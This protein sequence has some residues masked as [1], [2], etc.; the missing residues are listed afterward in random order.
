MADIYYY[1]DLTRR[2][3]YVDLIF[4]DFVDSQYVLSC[5]Q[6]SSLNFLFFV[7]ISNR[8]RV[9]LCE[10]ISKLHQRQRFDWL[11]KNKYK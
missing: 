2:F 5:I 3:I 6:H 1:I 8:R 4:I 9:V 11:S 10:L 7:F